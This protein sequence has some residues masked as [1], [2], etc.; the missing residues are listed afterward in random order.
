MNKALACHCEPKTEP[1]HEIGCVLALP[2][3]YLD[4]DSF[5]DRSVYGHL[6]TN[7]GSKWQLDGRYFDGNDCVEIPQHP[8]SDITKDITIRALMMS[9]ETQT[10]SC[11]YLVAKNNAYLLSWGHPTE[12]G[13]QGNLTFYDGTAWRTPTARTVMVKDIWYDFLGAYSSPYSITFID[14]DRKLYQDIGSY[15]IATNANNLYVGNFS[16]T[17]DGWVKGYIKLAQVYN[18]A[19]YAPRILSR[20]IGG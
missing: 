4:G 10:E 14:G 7:Y 16:L 11:S 3:K 6:C 17:G 19:D 13:W 2:F 18:F 8:A 1:G 20:S 12:A 5:M 15:S 9:E